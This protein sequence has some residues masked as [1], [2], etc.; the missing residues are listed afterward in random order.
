MVVPGTGHS[1]TEGRL[2][3][4]DAVNLFNEANPAPR[5]WRLSLLTDNGGTDDVE[6]DRID[7]LPV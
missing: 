7:P 6:L 5:C 4:D 2:S 3:A 1:V